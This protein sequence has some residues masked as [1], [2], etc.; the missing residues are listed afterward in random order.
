LLLNHATKLKNLLLKR[1]RETIYLISELD[2]EAVNVLKFLF[3]KVNLLLAKLGTHP[4]QFYQSV[5][6]K[7]Y[8]FEIEAIIGFQ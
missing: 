3:K 2:V 4:L 6:G 7:L 1:V 8:L 5:L